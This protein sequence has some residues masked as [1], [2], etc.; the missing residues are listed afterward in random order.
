[1]KKMSIEM[2]AV[3][4]CD[5]EKC[6]YNNGSVCHAKAITVGDFD[7][8]GCD[9]FFTSNSRAQNKHIKAGV[10]ACKVSSCKHNKDFECSADEISV[11]FKNNMVN[12]LTF[13]P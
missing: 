10:G 1:M 3:A 12:C 11:G 5:V 8:P 13:E 4:T 7:N 2:S 6:A 9:T